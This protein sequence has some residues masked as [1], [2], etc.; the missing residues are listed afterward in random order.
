[1]TDRSK[2]IIPDSQAVIRCL[3]PEMLE[4]LSSHGT[5][6]IS[7]IIEKRFSST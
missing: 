6:I 2:Q 4:I 1:M 5:F 3:D 7:E